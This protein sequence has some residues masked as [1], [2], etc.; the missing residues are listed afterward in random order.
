MDRL[1]S[2]ARK[3]I[4]RMMMPC[5]VMMMV[6]VM[7]MVMTLVIM[8][9]IVMMVMIVILM[10]MVMVVVFMVMFVM[11]LM[12]MT[13][14]LAFFMVMTALRTDDFIKKF[15]LQRL[16]RLH[17]LKDLFARKLSDR[18]GDKRCLVI[19]LSEQGNTLLDLLRFRLI[20]TA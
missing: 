9:M 11:M 7:I 5:M 8:L 14:A 10:V 3:H 18:S 20:C 1:A 16:A 6:V 4:I 12:V 15:F 13:A 19:E 2:P 17:C